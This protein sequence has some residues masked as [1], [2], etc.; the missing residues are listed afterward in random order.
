MAEWKK[1]IVSGSNIS[2][3]NNDSN[4]LQS[5][6]TTILSGSFSGS[7]QG[8]GS[9]LT[10]IVA[11]AESLTNALSSGVG[12]SP[13]TYNAEIPLE[14]AVSGAADLSA[15]AITKWNDTDGKFANSSLTDNGTLVTGAS[16]IRLTGG[17]SSLTGSF[18][19]TFSGSGANISGVVLGANTT[20]DY[21]ASLG[22]GTGVTIGAN[23]GEGS[24]PTIAVNYGSTASTAVQG[25]VTLEVT[26]TTNEIEV[27]NGTAAA[28]GANRSI[29]V[30]LPDNVTITSN[31][32]VGGNLRVNGDVTQINTTN[33][34]VEDTFILLNSGSSTPS[35][36]GI[37]FGGTNGVAQSGTALIWDSSYNTNDGR[38]S[39]ANTV[40][41]NATGA[42]TV[43]YYV[44]GV[45]EG[46]A[47][48]AATAQADHNG[49][50]RIDAGDIYIYA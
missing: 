23:T 27:T 19:G 45:F 2:Q 8:D 50:I 10:G 16:S 26:G 43:S 38:L 42:Q 33:L 39:I 29:T 5:G 22:T 40:A 34:E 41:S 9:G 13:F 3:L 30:G 17:I 24:T 6:D 47:V 15:N 31:L 35:D 37:I 4:Y 12:I 11:T 46:T 48:N 49:N 28:L 1:V 18:K 25:N 44:G 32:T 36:S 7:F 14:V 21:V 20:G